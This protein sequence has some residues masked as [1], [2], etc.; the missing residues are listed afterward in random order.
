MSIMNP[1]GR[2]PTVRAVRSFDM[3]V[4][5]EPWPF[6][7]ENAEKIGIHWAEAAAKN[8]ALFNGRVL[9]ARDLVIEDDI[10]RGTY[11]QIDFA[12]LLYWRNLGFPIQAQACN[13]FGS[14]V[15]VSR[16]GAVLL[17]AMGKHTANAG[18]MYFPA[19]TPDPNDVVGD[20]LDID[21]SLVR[22][23]REETGLGAD[24]VR[25]SETRWVVEDRPIVS[26]ARRVDTDLTAD[27]L[28]AHVNAFLAKETE[29]ELAAVRMVRSRADIDA[30]RMPAY[31][32]A[33]LEE[34]L[35]A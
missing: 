31:V 27:E 15:V 22:E 7:D 17:G 8:G 32:R 3:R 1:S 6:A 14:A 29:P 21:G 35:P 28:E 24:L 9:V 23:L 13:G 20:R 16:D 4:V 2:T 10:A 26:C 33:L 25:P 5:D 12:A 18:R 11:V 34:L 19:G 30:E